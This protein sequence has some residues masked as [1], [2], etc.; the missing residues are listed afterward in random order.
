MKV[1]ILTN[2]PFPNGMAATK[3]IMCYAQAI[4]EGG[5]DCEVLVFR[6]TEV[7]GNK[8]KNTVGRDTLNSIPFRY[9]GGTPLRGC[10]VFIR[11]INDRLDIW[12]TD[13]YLKRNLQKGDVLFL[14]MGKPIKL[15]LHFIKIA[16]SRNAYCVRDL[17]ELPY[18]TCAETDEA[19]HLRK[20]T[21][22]KLFPM[23]DGIISISD[24]L[25]HLAQTHTLS[26][27]KHIKVP[28][29]IDFEKYVIT[30][31]N[32]ESE[33]DIPYIF[34][35]GALTEQKDGILGMIKAFGIALNKMDTPAKFIFT[36]EVNESPH[37]DE[38]NALIAKYHLNDKICFTGYLSDDELKEYLGKARMVIINKNSTRQNNYCFSTKLGE[39][40]AAAKPV[41]ITNVGEAMNWLENGKSAYIVETEDT[42]ALA[43]AIVH[44]FAHPD[45]GRQIGIAG[46]E[47]CRQSFDYRNWSKP[48]VEFMNQLGK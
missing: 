8:P 26:N 17:C 7:Y 22:E 3:R 6:R 45:E 40:L 37:K 18:G 11:Q 48:L 44:V 1:I 16:H 24:A 5:L 35:A 38:V 43:N 20:V 34:H 30:H 15:M 31:P 12:K 29:M 46:Q 14:Y 28:I 33:S 21:I 36:G 23:F 39:Y 19:I 32:S 25:Q 2:E 10:N 4:K 41:V 13:K 42:E 47:V 27:C 9:A